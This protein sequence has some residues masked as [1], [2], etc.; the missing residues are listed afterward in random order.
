VTERFWGHLTTRQ[1]GREEFVIEEGRGEGPQK[2]FKRPYGIRG[3]PTSRKRMREHR[4]T[5]LE[6]EPNFQLH[7]VLSSDRDESWTY[8]SEGADPVERRE[9]DSFKRKGDKL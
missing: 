5:K 8:S 2:K 7:V 6:W 4:K 9:E 3:I 1:R